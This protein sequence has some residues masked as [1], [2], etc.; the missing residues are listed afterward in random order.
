MAFELNEF[1]KIDGRICYKFKFKSVFKYVSYSVFK[2]VMKFCLAL[3]GARTSPSRADRV[4][5]SG[6]GLN[7]KKER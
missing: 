3:L 2:S 4:S 1:G 7:E 5:Q 6:R